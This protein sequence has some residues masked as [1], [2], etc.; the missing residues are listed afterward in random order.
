MFITAYA[1]ISDPITVKL[2]LYESIESLYDHV[3]SFVFLDTSIYDKVDL[4]RYGKVRKH[5]KSLFN[6]FDNPFGSGF[7]SALRLADSDVV[8]FLDVDEIFTFHGPS[9]KDIVKRY[10]LENGAGISFSLLN[11]YCDRYHKADACSSKGPHVF[12]N[13]PD[14]AHDILKGYAVPHNHI[15]RTN[16]HP[17]ICDGVRVVNGAGEPMA[18]YQPV[19][20]DEVIVHHT[21]HLD[22]LGKMVRSILQFNHT[23]TIDLPMFFPFDM[24]FQKE[25]ID[26]IFEKGLEDIKNKDFEIYKEPLPHDYKPVKL[27]EDFIKRAEI[28]EF[29]PEGYPITSD[30]F[31]GCLQ[32]GTQP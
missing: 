25:A 21:S 18:Q 9:L 12:R 17:D 32:P 2:P 28:F 8:L 27:L 16:H 14:L 24:R 15:R 10:P 20:T 22:P 3:D 13:R 30:P 11:Y 4:S 1:M 7:T 5:V 29:D 23:N 26:M 31:T 6:C 19:S